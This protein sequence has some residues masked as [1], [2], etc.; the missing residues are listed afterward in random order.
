MPDEAIGDR[1]CSDAAGDASGRCPGSIEGQAAQVDDVGWRAIDGDGGSRIYKNSRRAAAIGD[2]ADRLV[3]GHSSVVRR[4]DRYDLAG[5]GGLRDCISERP[6]GRGGRGAYPRVG[7]FS[8]DISVIIE[9]PGR[10]GGEAKRN[11]C[12]RDQLRKCDFGHVNSLAAGISRILLSRIA[13]IGVTK[14]LPPRP[15]IRGCRCC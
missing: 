5:G 10:R 6:A 14:P 4:I 3:D 2:D 7:P 1:H 11:Q 12:A 15:L 13:R 9:R 8:R